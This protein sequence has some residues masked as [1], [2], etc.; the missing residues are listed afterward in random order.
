MFGAFPILL[1]M[2]KASFTKTKGSIKEDQVKDT[3]R[4][5]DFVLRFSRH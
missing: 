3:G 1:N 4:R 5:D 2:N